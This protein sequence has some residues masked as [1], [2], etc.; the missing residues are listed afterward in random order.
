MHIYHVSSFRR[1]KHDDGNRAKR[2]ID[3]AGIGGAG[4]LFRTE[5]DLCVGGD[6][7]TSLAGAR[8][9]AMAGGHGAR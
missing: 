9:G 2:S 6:G 5:R 8:P 7:G 4:S 1:S 3:V